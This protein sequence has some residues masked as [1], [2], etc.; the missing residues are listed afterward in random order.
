MSKYSGYMDRVAKFDLTTGKLEDYPWSDKEKELY[1][2]GKMM[3]AKILY[4][5]LTGK[6]EAFSEE[7]IIVI[8]TGP[9][10]D[11]GA[12]S[13]CRFNISTISP[14]TGTIASANCGGSFG[15]YLKRAGFDALIL[16]GKC[17][18]HSWLEIYNDTFILHNAD[19]EDVWGKCVSESEQ[20]IHDLLDRDYGCRVKCG[21]VS[22]GS[23]GEE[24]VPHAGVF[25]RERAEGSSGIGAVFGWKNLKAVAVAGNHHTTVANAKKTTAWNKKWVSYLRAHPLT[26]EQL[27]KFGAASLVGGAEAPKALTGEVSDAAFE[28]VSTAKGCISCPIKCVHAADIDAEE[29]HAPELEP[30]ALL[31]SEE[32]N[33]G[34][35][36]FL[37]T[38]GMRIGDQSAKTKADLTMLMQDMFE[39]IEACGQCPFT[40]YSIFPAV[41]FTQPNSPITLSINKKMA[42][43]GPVLSILNKHP[44][45]LFFPL[46][47]FHYDREMK[48][49]VGMKMNLGKYL[50][51]GERGYALEKYVSTLFAAKTGDEV[52]AE[53]STELETKDSAAA[54]KLK[55]AYYAVRGWSKD[56]VPSEASLKKLG[57]KKGHQ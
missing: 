14:R 54:D 45:L 33:A 30:L 19:S 35:P 10:T 37:E 3:A 8:S 29:V 36:A 1:L 48:Y 25:S 42:K 53:T 44:E 38:L 18:Q 20:Q 57:I 4:D 9:L 34:Y 56:G 41:L 40:A 6:E 16:T 47:V 31:C 46:S 5:N 50:R 27:P 43:L 24:L 11:T 17:P 2:G 32:L 49:A 21:I 28:P 15:M 52:P 39:S 13:S 26:G 55:K 51:C 23:A 7:N 12:P 22:I